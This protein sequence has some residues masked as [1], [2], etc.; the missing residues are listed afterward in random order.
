MAKGCTKFFLA[1]A[2]SEFKRL[3]LKNGSFPASF[4]LFSSFQTQITINT[5]NKCENVHPVY[6]AGIQTHDLWHMSLLQ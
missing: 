3:F 2:T 1:F 5:T 6:G 4:C